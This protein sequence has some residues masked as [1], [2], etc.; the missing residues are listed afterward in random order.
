MPHIFFF[1]HSTSATLPRCHASFAHPLLPGHPSPPYLPLFLSSQASWWG[2]ATS[3]TL[4]AHVMPDENAMFFFGTVFGGVGLLVALI[5]M[6]V[7]DPRNVTDDMVNQRRVRRIF[8]LA[9]LTQSAAV[10]AML[11]LS[12]VPPLR[13]PCFGRDPSRSSQAILLGTLT[14]L[15]GLASYVSFVAQA[16]LNEVAAHLPALTGM[17][18]P[19]QLA[20][21]GGVCCALLMGTLRLTLRL[22]L[23]DN[24]DV[25]GVIFLG[26]TALLSLSGVLVMPVI[27]RQ[28]HAH[29]SAG[30]GTGGLEVHVHH[31][32]ATGD[33]TQALLGHGSAPPRSLVQVCRAL[34][35]YYFIMGAD[36]AYVYIL[37]P[38]V[39]SVI[40][41]KSHSTAEFTDY[42]FFALNTAD[43]VG[44]ILPSIVPLAA[45]RLGTR[46]ALLLFE[47]CVLAPL[48]CLAAALP[49]LHISALALTLTVIVA[50][51]H[52]YLSLGTINAV[53][54]LI[55]HWPDVERRRAGEMIFTCCVIGAGLGS[56]VAMGLNYTPLG[57]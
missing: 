16:T 24:L 41:G 36:F 29:P 25:Q 40:Q 48:V 13:E 47:V 33:D 4:F 37:Y 42:L 43:F 32:N 34:G 38:G 50:T 39:I 23:R 20:W 28:L 55:A 11:L 31:V 5:N 9:L 7:I 21:L 26:I 30:A 54:E 56:F 10:L 27:H 49:A 52:G 15:F 17:M 12:F 53:V 8:V 57:Q 2:V 18:P 3:A 45:A 14:A 51:L 6:T 46:Y 35:G 19:S 1:D 44:K 22:A